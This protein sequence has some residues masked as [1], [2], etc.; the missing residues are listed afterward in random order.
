[1]VTSESARYL[2]LHHGPAFADFV[3]DAGAVIG[4]TPDPAALSEIA[5]RHG[6]DI[7]GPPPVP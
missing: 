4:A 1:V 6:I 3:T 7:V 5:A 2:T